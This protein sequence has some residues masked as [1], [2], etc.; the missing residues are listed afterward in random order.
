MDVALEDFGPQ[1]RPHQVVVRY[2]R[3]RVESL[4]AQAFASALAFSITFLA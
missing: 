3:S 1:I 2:P 4:R